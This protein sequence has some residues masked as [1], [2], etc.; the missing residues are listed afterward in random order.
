MSQIPKDPEIAKMFFDFQQERMEKQIELARQGLQS[1]SIGVGASVV[2]FA[3]LVLSAFIKTPD[4]QEL[5]SGD[6]L[7]WLA[8]VIV[9]GLVTYFALV[10]NREVNLSAKLGQFEAGATTGKPKTKIPPPDQS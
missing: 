8:I 1:G 10:F 5:F 7:V 2:L 9:G 6:Q 4:G 3:L